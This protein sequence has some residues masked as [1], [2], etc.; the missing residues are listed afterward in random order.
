MNQIATRPETSINQI[1]IA[2]GAHGASIAPQSLG[3]V[4]RF[5]E[6][7]CK[8]DIALP[9]HLRGN[10]GAC[11]AVALQALEWQMS[12]FAVASK[13]YAVNGTIAYE[14]QLIAA[15]VNTRSGIEGR[16][17]YR[18]EGDGDA[19]K[20]FVVG[21]IDGEEL[22]YESPAIGSI[23]P[24]NSPL[25]KTD[26][27][28]QLG[29]YSARAWARR[30]TPEVILGVYDREEAETFQ[31][32]ENAKDVTPSLTQRLALAKQT[33]QEGQ[34][35]REGFDADFVRSETAALSG[36]AEIEQETSAD[37]SPAGE[38]SDGPQA[39]AQSV[40]AL[41]SADEADNGEAGEHEA[42]DSQSAAPASPLD[43]IKQ[44]LM[45]ECIDNML[46]DAMSEPAIER[47]AKVD[48]L[49]DVFLEPQNLGDFADFV[50]RCHETARRI[51]GKPSE[52]DRAREYLIGKVPS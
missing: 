52:K 13:S 7:M 32:P 20:C 28:Q 25:W 47:P 8:A 43:P 23:H 48:K 26:P 12:P 45:E 22:D 44:M 30:H 36:V 35:T 27:Q 31:G 42:A 33:P 29:Y 39:P 51:I 24:K 5:S 11:M 21:K 15:V 3:E 17:K 40:A 37:A 4:V 19:M 34:Q 38:G 14:A 16:L 6:V 50:N 18:F 46:R 1:G 10:A 41:L 9:K 2:A 49:R